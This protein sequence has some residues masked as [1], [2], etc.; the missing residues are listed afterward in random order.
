MFNG[1]MTSGNDLKRILG[2]ARTLKSAIEAIGDRV[3]DH[4]VVEQAAAADAFN[5]E[6][7]TQETANKIAD[8]LNALAPVYERGWK[9]ELL[10]SG[11]FVLTKTVRSVVS[12]FE[13]SPEYLNGSEGQRLSKGIEVFTEFFN[14]AG[15]LLAED[16]K[17]TVVTGPFDFYKKVIEV[18]KKGLA[19]Q[20]YK[21]LGE[22]NPDQLWETTLDPETRSLLQVKVAEDNMASEIFSTLMGDIVEPRRDFIIERALDVKNLDA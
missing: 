13:I 4:L 16:G 11:S 19:I 9:G 8:R 2:L 10:E 18:A 1:D 20:R 15:A 17:E 21:G 7:R 6:N 14:A 5:P 22:M 3:G 12:R